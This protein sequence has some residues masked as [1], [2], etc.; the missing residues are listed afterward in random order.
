LR[1][2]PAARPWHAVAAGKLLIEAKA[3]IPHGQWLMWLREHV[4]IPERTAQRYMEVAPWAKSDTMADLTGEAIAQLAPPRPP[5]KAES[6]EEMSAWAQ[7]ELDSPFT[8]KDMEVDV[9]DL[10]LPYDT[11]PGWRTTKLL[12]QLKVPAIA[13]FCMSEQ[14]DDNLNPLHLCPWDEL[15]QAIE[16]LIPITKG[17]RALKADAP[18]IRSMM[19]II[20]T[21]KCEAMWF[22]GGLLIE[23]KRREKITD[24]E[25]EAE[26]TETHTALMARFAKQRAKFEKFK[27]KERTTTT[28]ERP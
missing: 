3:Q 11:G 5:D 27:K 12:H 6:Y 15:I 2:S 14:R 18:D 1:V 22:L 17:D 10:H 13:S 4:Q 23:I 21:L 25:F 26:W 16:V 24:E 7:C 28:G 9:I 19:E 8:K 20:C